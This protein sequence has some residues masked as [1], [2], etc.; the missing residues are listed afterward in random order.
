MEN[1]GRENY[2]PPQEPLLCQ[3]D[4]DDANPAPGLRFRYAEKWRVKPFPFDAAGG[5]V[6]M[7]LHDTAR[8]RQ[9]TQVQAAGL[10]A[11]EVTSEANA[12]LFQKTVCLRVFLSSQT[13]ESEI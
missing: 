4:L 8:I 13:E 11:R 1:A 7:S 2:Q 9:R 3:V 10:P 12:G 5:G 6:Q